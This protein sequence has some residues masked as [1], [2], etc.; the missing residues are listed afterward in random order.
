MK[1]H[2]QSIPTTIEG[3][4]TKD[5]LQTWLAGLEEYLDSQDHEGR[6]GDALLTFM[7]LTSCGEVANDHEAEL[8]RRGI[9]LGLQIAAF[10]RRRYHSAVAAKNLHPPAPTVTDEQILQAEALYATR[11][12]QA[13]HLGI[14]KRQLQRRLAKMKA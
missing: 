13:A 2:L 4:F 12:E 10:D 14:G 8:V 1:K 11:D 7:S 5:D 3:E 6:G 9:R